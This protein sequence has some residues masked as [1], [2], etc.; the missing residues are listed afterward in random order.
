MKIKYFP[1]IYVLLF[2]AFS[3]L[4]CSNANLF[5]KYFDPP[6]NPIE[7]GAIQDSSPLEIG[8]NAYFL[9]DYAG[10][11]KALKPL[12]ESTKS[13]NLEAY[14]FYAHVLLS[15]GDFEKAIKYFETAQER[16]IPHISQPAHWYEALTFIKK[17]EPDN[18]KK[19][20]K[21]IIAK[22]NHKYHT[23]AQELLNEL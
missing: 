20:L 18:A 19:I 17:G 7:K 22:S 5:E 9:G 4:S 12:V 13:L 3:G 14:Y 1:S 23:K 11:K 8:I 21:D 10:C 16:L 6:K 2:I 15:T